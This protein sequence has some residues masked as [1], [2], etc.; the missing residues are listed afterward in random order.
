MFKA[1]SFYFFFLSHIPYLHIYGHS[2]QT[3]CT[4]L[5]NSQIQ[6]IRLTVQSSGYLKQLA[7]P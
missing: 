4:I 1:I 7:Q 2:Y 3:V 6:H 5:I